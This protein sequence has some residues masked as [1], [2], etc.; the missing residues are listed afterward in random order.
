MKIYHPPLHPLPSREGRERRNI[1]SERGKARKSPLPLRE[2][3]PVRQTGDRV[4]G[5]FGSMTAYEALLMNS[6]IIMSLNT[7]AKNFVIVYRISPC[8]WFT[9]EENTPLNP[10]LIEGKFPFEKGA[11][12]SGRQG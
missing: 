11:C 10:L 3:L 6:L 1:L 4:R 9:K 5:I 12:L 8:P 2:S 7:N